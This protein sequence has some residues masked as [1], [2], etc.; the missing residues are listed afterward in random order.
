MREKRRHVR[1]NLKKN[2][3]VEIQI[4]GDMFLEVLFAENISISGVGIEVPHGFKECEMNSVVDLILTLPR[5]QPF[6]AKGT[7]R[8]KKNVAGN[9]HKGHFG[10]EFTVISPEGKE[11]IQQL[12]QKRL[13]EIQEQ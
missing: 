1:V 8:H 10:V 6:K 2:D 4:M 7:I 13:H 9:F 12:I 3:P 5:E 11:K